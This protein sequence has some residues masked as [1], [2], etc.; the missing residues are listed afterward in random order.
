MS[1]ASSGSDPACTMSSVVVEDTTY[2]RCGKNWFQKALA[3]GE[4]TYVVVNPPPGH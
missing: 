3:D 1:A 2:Y 4:V